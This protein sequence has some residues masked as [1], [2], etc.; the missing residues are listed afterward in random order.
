MNNNIIIL[1]GLV[2]YSI[3]SMMGISGMNI[4]AGI[5]V[6]GLFTSMIR[7]KKAV[8]FTDNKNQQI[9]QLI[10]V[11]IL[12]R[13]VVSFLFSPNKTISFSRIVVELLE[14]SLLFSVINVCNFKFKLRLIFLIIITAFLQSLY[15]ILQFFTGIDIIHKCYIQ[16]YDRIR[17]TLSHW[18]T[19]GGLLGMVIPIIFAKLIYE[20]IP[21]YKL[22]YIVVFL[23]SLVALVFTKTRGAWFGC[24]MAIITIAFVRFKIKTIFIGVILPLLISFLPTVKDKIIQT[25]TDPTFSGRIELWQMS[26]KIM[27]SFYFF[28]GYGVDA[29][30]ILTKRFHPHNIYLNHLNDTGLVG[31][32]IL[33]MFFLLLIRYVWK[34][35]K[36][37]QNTQI[38]YLYLGILGSFI[39]FMLHGL[40]DNIMRSETAFLFWFLV[41]ISFS[42]KQDYLES[43]LKLDK[44]IEIYISN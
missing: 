12:W 21:K 35:F 7:Q 25:V 17:G 1:T 38:S 26:L 32:V 20:K 10:L 42:I 41:G 24:Y 36:I 23:T 37:Y 8:M 28:T 2:V 3:F 16:A 6:L 18:N 43:N 22:F 27:K 34:T 31:I 44:K 5:A 30:E 15:G 13:I 33:L 4:G 19:L 14:M 11:Y 9:I 29:F 39:D 40:V